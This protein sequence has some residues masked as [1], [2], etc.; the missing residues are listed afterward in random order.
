MV[1]QSEPHLQIVHIPGGIEDPYAQQPWERAP[2]EP[3][4]GEEVTVHVVTYPREASDAVFVHRSVNGEESGTVSATRVPW[5]GEGDRWV[6]SLGIFPGGARV[7]YQVEAR[8]PAGER[9]IEGPYSFDV[10][11]WH[12]LVAVTAW[13]P[14]GTGVLM[15]VG[16]TSSGGALVSLEVLDEGE[17]QVRVWLHDPLTLPGLEHGTPGTAR[18]EGDILLLES[19]AMTVR[20]HLADGSLALQRNGEQLI[21]SWQGQ[22]L[23]S[24]LGADPTAARALRL[25][26]ALTEGEALY[27]TGERFDAFN[28]RG[29]RFDV[30]VYEQ[31]KN[32]G[33]RTYLPVPLVLSSRGY[34]LY[35]EGT[36][37]LLIDAGASASDA[38]IIEADVDRTGASPFEARLFLAETPLEAL[39]SYLRRV[40]LPALPP[41]WSFG[42]WMSSNDWNSQAWVLAEVERGEQEGIPGDVVVIEAWSDEATFY[43]WNDAQYA[44]LPGDRPPRLADFHFPPDGRWPDPLG[45]IEQLHQRGMRLLLWQ[46]PLL[47][48]MEQELHT[49]NR[50]DAETIISHGWCARNPDGSPYRNPGW[51]FTGALVPDF[52]SSEASEWWR[53][54]RRYLVEEMGVDGFKTDGGEHLW[55]S[56][57]SFADGRRGDEMI[58]AFPVLYGEI[59]HQLLR[60]YGR[61]D[62]LTFSRAGYAGSQRY[63]AHWAGDEDSTWEAFRH[64]IVAGLSAGASG[65]PFWGWDIAGFSGE[66]PSGELYRRA[67]MMATFCPIMQYHSEYHAGR[68]PNRDRTPW[69][70]AERT[71]DAHVLPVC[72]FYTAVRRRLRPYI[73]REA[74]H[75]ARTGRPLM[76]ALPLAYPIDSQV[77]AYPYQ[78]LFGRDLLV[79][80]TVYEGAT[81]QHVYLPAG[82]WYDLWTH[83]HSEGPCVMTVDSPPNR[84]PVYIRA[85]AEAP[86]DSPWGEMT[87]NV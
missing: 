70:I 65:I 20:I 35:L 22:P 28:R 57:V 69:N 2:R 6:A 86:L 83:T 59:Y 81:S 45:M 9:F 53:A 67:W 77:H 54:R 10:S 16:E 73:L 64:S 34:A 56:G 87:T 60:A 36:R 48:Q 18:Q 82:V 5:E 41:G 11:M 80:P 78:Y 26:V 71:A 29:H 49:Q 27:G 32:Q 23:L 37:P 51:W 84:I 3:R 68:Q 79:A 13:Q 75:T 50:A 14:T 43:I 21:H 4:V 24:W 74:E 25:S 40:G 58:N 47:K 17:L 66:I 55:G 39:Q 42:L 7:S 38:L 12:P 19:G 52:T 1:K 46:I 63:P 61:E 33:A 31:Y 30:R 72:R 85:G 15:H 62:G 44:L 76:C 8:P